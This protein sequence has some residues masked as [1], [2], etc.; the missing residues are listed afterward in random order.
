MDAILI[1]WIPIEERARLSKD[2]TLGPKATPSY[3]FE[4][5]K[6]NSRK[7]LPVPSRQLAKAATNLRR[8]S[9]DG[10]FHNNSLETCR[11]AALPKAIRDQ[12]L[13]K[14]VVDGRKLHME[15][16]SHEYQESMLEYEGQQHGM[17][18]LN[19][20]DMKQMLS[21]DLRVKQISQE[22]D[23][24]PAWP[25]Y[26]MWNY[27]AS[28]DL[29]AVVDEQVMQTDVGSSAPSPHINSSRAA[30]DKAA[31]K[32]SGG[33]DALPGRVSKMRMRRSSSAALGSPAKAQ[34]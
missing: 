18:E 7:T 16:A 25:L 31:L 24:R 2:L 34:R 11:I 19:I 15:S 17:R 27:L 8:L 13:Y 5:G 9:V 4:S 26:L 1:K 33:L 23:S 32:M 6:G 20:E 14:L 28:I 22:T 12:S 3:T 10:D 30:A 29:R 21:G